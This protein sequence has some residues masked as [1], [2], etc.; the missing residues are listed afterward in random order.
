MGHQTA[1]R[2]LTRRSLYYFLCQFTP[3]RN[4]VYTEGTLAPSDVASLFVNLES[5]TGTHSD[6]GYMDSIPWKVQWTAF[7]FVHTD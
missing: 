5:I 6:L 1:A 7:H 2:L 3:K 4:Y